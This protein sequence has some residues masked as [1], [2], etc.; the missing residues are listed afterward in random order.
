[1]PKHPHRDHSSAP[2]SGDA[3]ILQQLGLAIVTLKECLRL[4]IGVG[5]GEARLD[6]PALAAALRQSGLSILP[7]LTLV[8]ATVGVILGDQTVSFLQGLDLPGLALL[9]LGYGVVMEL[10]PVLVGILVAG[11]AG[12]ALAVRQASLIVSGE[13]DGLL[14]SGINPLQFTVGPVLLAMLMMSF[15]FAVWSAFV[16]FAS[17]FLWLWANAGVP[18]VLFLDA[19]RRSLTAADLLEALAKPLVFALVIGLVAA[20]NGTLAGRDPQGVGRAATRTMIGA[21]T[22]IMLI[23]LGFVLAGSD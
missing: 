20:V 7:A 14:V 22:A 3:G 21:V 10:V 17:A 9:S 6:L 15:A 12:V 18:P 1:M 19:L 13:M 11:R 4:Y 5:A 16:T 2:P 23:D 8:S